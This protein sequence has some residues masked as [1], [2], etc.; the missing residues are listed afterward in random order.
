LSV[1][2]RA[3]HPH[4]IARLRGSDQRQ[5]VVVGEP[6]RD[7]WLVVHA[8]LREQVLGDLGSFLW[9]GVCPEASKLCEKSGGPHENGL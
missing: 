7:D 6:R 2:L 1:P 4:L 9:G 5:V 8:D 3:L